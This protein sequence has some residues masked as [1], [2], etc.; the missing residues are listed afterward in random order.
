MLQITVVAQ[1]DG[2][3]SIGKGDSDAD[4][5]A[6][7]EL[8]STN[9]GLLIPRLSS[10]EREGISS[11]ANGL[12][13]YDTTYSSLYYWNGAIW[14]QVAGIK[15]SSGIN[16]PAGAVENDLFYKTS[17]NLLYIYS[18]GSWL[19]V[20]SRK[21]VL[22]LDSTTLKLLEE[23]KTTGSEVDLSVLFQDLSLSGTTL[24]ISD[25]NSVNLGA[26]N[27]TLSLNSTILTLTNGG[28]VDFTSLLTASNISISPVTGIIGHQCAGC[29][30][31]VEDRQWGYVEIGL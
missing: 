1:N 14:K 7:L 8:V 2:G 28:S 20:G 24:T 16:Y 29:N 11:P 27:Q 25:G 5:S 18:S 12:I 31:R 26:L 10:S 6:I 22:E 13:V 19:A 9:K 4:P 23:G 3:V 21:Q 30:C 15:L 17:D